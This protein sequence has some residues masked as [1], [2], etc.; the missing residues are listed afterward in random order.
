M[1][2]LA[3]CGS[4]EMTDD[5][6]GPDFE[7]SFEL[8]GELWEANSTNVSI[9]NGYI[10]LEATNNDGHQ[11]KVV[12]DNE[13]VEDY[14]LI[15]NLN[16]ASFSF[17]ASD[18][19]YYGSQYVSQ[20][21]TFDVLSLDYD[22]KTISGEFNFDLGKSDLS[23][24][25]LVITSGV[26]NLPFKTGADI[27]G[28]SSI[29]LTINNTTFESE[30]VN[31]TSNPE[32]IYASG[33]ISDNSDDERFMFIFNRDFSEVGTIALNSFGPPNGRYIKDGVVYRTI[34]SE[35]MMITKH[36]LTNKIIEGTFSFDMRNEDQFSDT[37]NAENGSFSISY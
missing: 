19:E 36:D 37:V 33:S 35:E 4:D 23:G 21:A 25:T 14:N 11:L 24:E 2:T 30:V 5:P 6:V 32:Y 16:I 9:D 1:I 22:A 8:N 10:I 20:F 13:G 28:T 26:F 7:F 3:S 12:I 29:S 18:S 15:G 27:T 17:D 31:A 34:A